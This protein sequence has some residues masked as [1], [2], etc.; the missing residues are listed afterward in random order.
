[1][2]FRKGGRRVECEVK[3]HGKNWVTL[4]LEGGQEKSHCWVYSLRHLAF[5]IRIVCR[6]RCERGKKSLMSAVSS[7]LPVFAWINKKIKT[8]FILI[9]CRGFEFTFRRPFALG[10]DKCLYLHLKG[11][12]KKHAVATCIWVSTIYF[13]VASPYAR[14]LYE[15]VISKAVV[16]S[17]TQKSCIHT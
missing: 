1:M 10:E 16:N 15:D 7:F 9:L 12:R 6:G 11:L 2:R 3:S 4:S 14:L 13:P 8:R 5:L 17:L